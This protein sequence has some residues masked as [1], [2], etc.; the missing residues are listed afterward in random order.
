[1]LAAC[2]TLKDQKSIDEQSQD[3]ISLASLEKEVNKGKGKKGRGN[4]P[5]SMSGKIRTYVQKNNGIAPGKA[6]YDALRQEYP[7]LVSK[8][9]AV[10][11][12]MISAAKR[13][14]KA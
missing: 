9:D 14:L 8:S 4:Q 6:G 13:V 10:L 2:L 3:A 5:N 1:M 12:A 11:A 7:E